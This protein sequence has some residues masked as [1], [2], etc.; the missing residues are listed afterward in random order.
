MPEPTPDTKTTTATDAGGALVS[1]TTAT[2]L[3]PGH[4]TTE[5][6]LGV[7]AIILTALYSA[8]AIPT[9]TVYAKI[10]AVA[11][12]VLIALGYTVVR[13]KVKAAAA[14]LVLLFGFAFVA[15]SSM[16]CGHVADSARAGAGAFVDCMKPATHAAAAELEPAFGSVL[17]NAL[18]S[19]GKID[20]AS[21]D[22]IA[23]PLKQDA[24]RCALDG[25]ITALLHPPPPRPGAPQSSPLEVDEADVGD[26]Y[27]ELRAKLWGD[28]EIKSA[29]P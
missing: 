24:S 25:A 13:G 12:T 4:K 18:A 23:A 10:A 16:G 15:T 2:T 1:A 14:M 28:V 27:A 7:A 19:D 22:A 5:F 29:A 8:D 3:K 20:R 17:R 26:A 11:A 21:L 9:G 6:A